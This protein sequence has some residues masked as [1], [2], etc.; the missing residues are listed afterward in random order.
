MSGSSTSVRLAG[1]GETRVVAELLAGAFEDDPVFSFMFPSG[2]S[3]R[4][5]RMARMFGIDVVRSQRLG[6]VWIADDASAAAVWYPPGKWDASSL[7]M[8]RQSPQWLAVFGRR[9][10]AA[11]RVLNTLQG[12]HRRLDPHWYLY[13]MGTRVDRRSSGRGS[14][15]LEAVLQR[16]DDEQT[17]AYLEASTERKRALYAR[18]GF[19]TRDEI[20]VPGGG[21]TMFPMWRTPR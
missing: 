1:S 18:H 16:C 15:L 10:P 14:A 5:Q 6:G 8:L 17:P 21:P 3:R 12:Q 19:E 9:L 11:T 13:Y 4:W 7:E 20:T 2:T